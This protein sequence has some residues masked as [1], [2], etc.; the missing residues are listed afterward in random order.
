MAGFGDST[1]FVIVCA[2]IGIA[3]VIGGFLYFTLFSH[4][5]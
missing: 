4:K 3:I 1:W 2:I 5:G